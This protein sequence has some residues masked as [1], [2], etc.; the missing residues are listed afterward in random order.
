MHDGQADEVN[1]GEV[2]GEE[3]RDCVVVT[4]VRNAEVER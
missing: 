1:L 3:D 2:E 4:A